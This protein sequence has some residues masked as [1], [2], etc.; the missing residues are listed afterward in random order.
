MKSFAAA[1][2]GLLFAAQTVGLQADEQEDYA[3]IIEDL[4]QGLELQDVSDRAY[5]HAEE[6]WEYMHGHER[7]GHDHEEHGPGTEEFGTHD[8]ID[9]ELS[10]G[11]A[12]TAIYTEAPALGGVDRLALDIVEVTAA[13]VDSWP[14]C[15]DTFD[16]V[17]AAVA[18]EPMR[19]DEIVARIAVKRDCNCHN[20][21]LWLDR[22][23]DD[24]LRVEMRHAV[25]DVLPQCSC[26][27][28]AMYA[29]IAGLP[30]NR[31]F[32][33]EAS[34]EEKA[35]VIAS[36]VE[37]VQVITD[38]TSA[39]QSRRGWECGC[40]DINLAA[41]MQGI[42]EDELRDG[43]YEGIA[44]KYVDD[45]ADRGLV[46]DSFGIVGTYPKNFWG[47]GK[48]VSRN[49]VLRRKGQVFRGDN[50]ILDPFNPAT[51]FE[52][53]GGRD[54]TN[55][56]RHA[57]TSDNIPTDLF[58]SEYVDDWNAEA[59][60]LPLQEREPEQR[61]RVLELYNGSDKTIDLG[62]DQYFL[63]IYAGP[64]IEEAVVLPAPPVLVKK[65]ISL[66]ADVL[67]DFDK[68][69][70][71]VEA[72]GDL[73][74]V[75]ALLNEVDFFSEILIVGNTCDMGTDEYNLALSERRANSVRDYL[76]QNGLKDVPLRTEGR[77]ESNP[78][79]PNTSIANR[80]LN[81]NVQFV[82]VTALDEDVETVV[83]QDSALE[84]KQYQFTWTVP[85]PA[86]VQ[87]TE[88]EPA[89]SMVAGEYVEGDMDPRQVIGLN[90][91]V[92]P[93]ETWVIAFDESDEEIRDIADQVT[94]QLDFKPNETLV[95]RRLGGEMALFCRASSYHYVNNYPALPFIR[96]PFEPPPR[97]GPID[98]ASPN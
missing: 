11:E 28:V 4:K 17:R 44:E 66:G 67:F 80:Q 8:G 7:D 24:R 72:A 68:S 74:Q 22:R 89:G 60:E 38:R 9:E 5:E 2:T 32:D 14:D 79:V 26:S 37:R 95:V 71:R 20:G 77:G 31:E 85:V 29:G 83:M 42:E 91:A 88:A 78:R 82:Y 87:T 65:T 36:M 63:E 27:Q 64:P 15:E 49:N 13:V 40:T 96:V 50:L 35:E 25:L 46:V 6:Y 61:N 16:A 98:L 70:I 76:V 34:D 59:L 53:Q 56:D 30:E 43:A 39:Q 90:G 55:L 10:A 97:P 18:L 94:G 86:V 58:I 45:A 75:L 92:E 93:G 54:Y 69:D 81:R 1:L 62:G 51:E 33:P 47:E 19:A 73:D 48:D 84:P 21:G 41:S 57:H 12:V 52:G 23:V 3:N